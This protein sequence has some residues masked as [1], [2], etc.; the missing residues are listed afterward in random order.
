MYDVIVQTGALLT[1]QCYACR[2]AA[3]ACRL[4]V[5]SVQLALHDLPS[6]GDREVCA[7]M[8]LRLCGCPQLVCIMH[9]LY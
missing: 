5:A 3:S 2:A 9:G 8:P 7:M 4:L 6:L 1:A